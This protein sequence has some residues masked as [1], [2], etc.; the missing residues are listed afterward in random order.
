MKKIV[1]SFIIFALT[2]IKMSAQFTGASIGETSSG[3]SSSGVNNTGNDIIDD[4]GSLLVVSVWDGS[5][6]EIGYNF[7]NGAQ[8]G[9]VALN[10]SGAVDP[11]VCLIKNGN[12]NIYAVVVLHETPAMGTA[13]YHV[14]YYRWTGSAIAY[15]STAVLSTVQYQTA[16]NVDGDN[17]GNFVIVW[18]QD[19]LAGVHSVIKSVTGSAPGASAPSLNNSPFTVNFT[20][21]DDISP[22]V[23]LFDDGNSTVDAKYCWVNRNS[24]NID[25]DF[26]R[27][28]NP[29]ISSS[30]AV[31]TNAVVASSATTPNSVF[32]YPRIACPN[33]NGYTCDFAV[34]A[35]DNNGSN[36]YDILTMVNYNDCS[37]PIVG[38]VV[39]YPIL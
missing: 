36:P 32:R 35:E 25:V 10:H 20:S 5:V 33:S 19:S 2:A 4:N 15:G 39:V 24:G 37:S 7:N 22:D 11:D 14:E 1:I 18:D 34:V 30:P 13:A 23:S 17:F 3:T 6:P 29:G 8:T 27:W 38:N 9:R 28:P 12:G 31:V 16:I 21:D 26:E